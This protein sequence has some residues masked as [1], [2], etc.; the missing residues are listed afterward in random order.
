MRKI[1]AVIGAALLAAC[2]AG[3][4]VPTATT[5]ADSFHKQLN[6]GQYQAIYDGSDRLMKNAGPAKGLVNLLSAVHRKLG[7]FQSAEQP[8]WNDQVTTNG[9]FVTLIYQSKYA[10]GPA[11][12]NFVFRIDG[13]RA[14]LVGWHINS[15]AFVVN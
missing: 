9:H 8:G 3:N 1:G 5:A 2:S 15:S 13:G 10:R 6:A 14:V 4:D 12:E 11:E 7:D